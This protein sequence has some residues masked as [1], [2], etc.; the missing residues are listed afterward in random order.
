MLTKIQ[1]WGN[2]QGLRLTKALLNEAGIHVGDEVNV[3]VQKGQIIVEPVSSVLGVSRVQGRYDL[4]ALLSEMSKEYQPEELD[5]GPP[6]G[7]EVW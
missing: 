7:K 1:K 2:S 3:S 6:A 4:K 5:W